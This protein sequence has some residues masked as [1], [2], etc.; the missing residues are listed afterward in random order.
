MKEIIIIIPDSL[1]KGFKE[2]VGLELFQVVLPYFHTN[3]II[4]MMAQGI[5]MM[6]RAQINTIIQD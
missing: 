5:P 4:P 2:A 1:E 3:Q 6:I